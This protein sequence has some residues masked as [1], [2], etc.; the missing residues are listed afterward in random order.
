MNTIA[1]YISQL[2]SLER[3][4]TSVL[5]CVSV[6]YFIHK[7][8]RYEELATSFLVTNTLQGISNTSPALLSCLPITK[9][10]LGKIIDI[11]KLNMYHF[12]RIMFQAVFISSYSDCLRAGEVIQSLVKDHTYKC[13]KLPLNTSKLD[14][15]TNTE[16]AIL[17]AS[18]LFLQVTVY[19]L[20]MLCNLT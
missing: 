17:P 18:I 11:I 10:I 13:H 14:I 12:E 16:L 1:L 20:L 8:T 9:A 5:C 4:Y 2:F 3:Q 19:V 15:H 7:L 6:I